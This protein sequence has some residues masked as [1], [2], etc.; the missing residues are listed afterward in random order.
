MLSL[1][2][3]GQLDISLGPEMAQVADR[4]P[5][6]NAH[7]SSHDDETHVPA[8]RSYDEEQRAP[9]LL[10]TVS[11]GLS[12]SP[13]FGLTKAY[14]LQPRGTIKVSPAHLPVRS[15]Q[16]PRRDTHKQED[17]GKHGVDLAGKD[18]ESEQRKAPDEK[19]QRHYRIVLGGCK[20]GGIARARV[21]GA[22]LQCRELQHSE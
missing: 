20:A 8:E 14:L 18:E 3:G 22:E 19:I 21:G 9:S 11:A 15:R 4:K 5:Q 17:G 13:I 10:S 1:F 2:R 16:H 12:Q 6:S 7:F